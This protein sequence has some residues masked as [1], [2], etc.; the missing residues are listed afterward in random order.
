MNE[1]GW[2]QPP[3]A[4]LVE[5]D[6]GRG[7]RERSREKGGRGQVRCYWAKFGRGGDEGNVEP[8]SSKL[9]VL[10]VDEC[11]EH[12]FFGEVDSV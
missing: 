9:Y 5:K 8:S 12:A 10:G 4:T 11:D 6:K 3:D 2:G 7:G 1:D